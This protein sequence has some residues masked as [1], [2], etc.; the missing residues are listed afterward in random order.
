MATTDARTTGHNVINIQD[1]GGAVWHIGGILNLGST[2]RVT[3]QSTFL[4]AINSLTGSTQC[5]TQL[6]DAV[7]SILSALVSLKLIAST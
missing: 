2:G 1:Q 7:N 3:V 6:Y 5:T 4:P